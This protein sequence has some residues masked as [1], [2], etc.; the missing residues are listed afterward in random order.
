MA[1]RLGNESFENARIMFRNF[2]GLES[3]YN[4]DGKR[5]F[6][7]IIDDTARAEKLKADGWNVRVSNYD[8]DNP[9]YYIPVEVSFNNYPPTIVKVAGSKKTRLTEETVGL[10]DSDDI[11]YVDLVISPY[12]W[13]VNGKAGV[14]AYVKRMYV[15]VDVDAFEAKYANYESTDDEEDDD[16]PF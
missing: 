10:L 6:C 1:E 12:T 5:N 11:K 16:L 14:K 8:E 13:E 2:K 3:K 4:R 9:T 7:V 15:V